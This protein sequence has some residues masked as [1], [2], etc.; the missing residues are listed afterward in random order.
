MISQ[1]D[2]TKLSKEGFRVLINETDVNLPTGEIVVNGMDFRNF[3][4]LH[5][6]AMAFVPCGGRPEAVDIYNVGNLI[7]DGKCKIP[8][9]VEGANLYTSQIRVTHNRFI[10]QEAKLRLEK[11]GAIIYKD[12]SAN[13]GGVTSSSLEGISLSKCPL[14]LVLASL[15]FNDAE[16]T[17]HMC[18]KNDV[19]PAF[20]SRYIENVQRIIEL[21]ARLEFEAIWREHERTR[22]PRCVLS[23]EI[24]DEIIKLDEQLQRTG[25]WD[26]ISLRK[27]IMAEALPETLL[28]QLDLDTILERVPIAYLK[29]IFGSFLASRFIYLHG[30]GAS[31]FAFFDFMNQKLKLA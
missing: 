18:L 13:K 9:I 15:S 24:S 19:V 20:Y 7:V 26:N 12:S 3:Y 6:A 29:G 25:L 10:T 14:I 21:N 31:Q 8:Y 11:A 2:A 5:S 28:E 30:V 22:K 16:F 27:T 4:H 23:D 17:E 1:F